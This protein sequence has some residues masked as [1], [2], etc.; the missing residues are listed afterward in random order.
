MAEI[1]SI[2]LSEIVDEFSL[3]II[4]QPKPLDKMHLFSSD[5][6]RPGLQLAGFYEVYD[7]KR[8]Q[9]IGKTE[10]VYMQNIP[11]GEQ[12][13]RWDD[14]F[15][16]RPPA[17]IV[18][19]SLEIPKEM[20]DAAKKYNVPFFSTNENTSTFMSALISSLNVALAPRV[21][22]HGVL[23]EV[24]GEGLLLFGDSG[25]GKSET[26]IELVMRGH[27]LIADDAVELRR[28]SNK[29]LV[30]A[31]PANIRHFAELRGIGIVN[32]R[33]LFGMAS[34][35]TTEKIAMIISLEVWD[36][37]K[38]YDRLGMEDEY[39]EIL[40]IQIPCITIPVT[41]GRNLAVIIEVA[42]MNLRQK[43]MG[44]NGAKELFQRLGMPEGGEAVDWEA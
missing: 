32:A 4:H 19:R 2:N 6:N 17:V 31:S 39:M 36:P 35:K 37:K 8:V 41:P 7:P 18:C 43:K 28:V 40:G 10:I 34:V 22:R 9:I 21:T 24:Y 38:P 13:K 30:G 25:V 1:Y 33:R 20:V 5:V 16:Q 29:A 14:L 11:A 26:A 27:R 3:E 42:A 23:V 15:A 44:Y 12:A